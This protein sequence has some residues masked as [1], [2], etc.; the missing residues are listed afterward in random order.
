MVRKD[1][2]LIIRIEIVCLLMSGLKNTYGSRMFD[3]LTATLCHTV[4]EQQVKGYTNK[5]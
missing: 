5:K 2:I 3:T 1:I 4:K